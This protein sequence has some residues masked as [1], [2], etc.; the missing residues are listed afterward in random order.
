MP[1]AVYGARN[2]GEVLNCN[3]ARFSRDQVAQAIT[4]LFERNLIA[5]GEQSPSSLGM[6]EDSHIVGLDAKLSEDIPFVSYLWLTPRGGAAWEDYAQPDW[7]KFIL[8]DMDTNGHIVAFTCQHPV[9]RMHY[10]TAMQQALRV[11]QL[12]VL[13]EPVGSWAATYWKT[14]VG[15]QR[16]RFTQ[17]V[18][19]G[20]LQGIGVNG[21]MARSHLV[22]LWRRIG[23]S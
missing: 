16:V 9:L 5:I 6:V 19:Q 15:G 7:R 8:E 4:S 10:C 17:G 11:D 13:E 14:L 3:A 18:P 21:S 2:F 20:C 22:G 1:L 12:P 23:L